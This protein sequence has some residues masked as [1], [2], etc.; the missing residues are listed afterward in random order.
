MVVFY[1]CA[2]DNKKIMQPLVV[3]A[4]VDQV[5]PSGVTFMGVKH[6][7]KSER[8]T[9]LPKSDRWRA[10]QSLSGWYRWEKKLKNGEWQ[11][12][13]GADIKYPQDAAEI[14]KRTMTVVRPA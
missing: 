6:Y 13:G 4:F 10:H 14:A 8:L 7:A 1:G 3:T 9:L 5:A 12:G 11:G 2:E